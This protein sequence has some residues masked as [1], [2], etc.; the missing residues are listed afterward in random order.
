MTQAHI[1]SR[2]P[3]AQVGPTLFAG[4]PHGRLD[5]VLKAV[6]TAN[7]SCVVL[8]GDIEPEHPLEDEMCSLDASGVAWYF[9][10]GNH[11][12]DSDEFARHVWNPRTETHDVHSRV[13]ELP[14]GLKLAG[15]AGVW[16]ASVWHPGPSSMRR[17]QPAWRSRDAHARATPRQDRWDGVL[18]PRKHLSSIYPDEFDQL[19]AS[20]AD[21]LVSHEAP[22]YHPRGF[23]LL[24][25]LARSLRVRWSVHGHHHDDLNSSAVWAAQGFES[26]GVGLRGVSAL[27]SDGRW[28]T[29]IAGTYQSEGAPRLQRSSVR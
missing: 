27:H 5:Q 18:P 10:G 7:A 14:N 23:D 17:G 20:R 16:R 29:V 13:V 11:D 6:S 19:A 1:A 21:I 8:L 26:H 22:G 24:D 3:L 15:L 28:E 9:I 2:P 25:E 12:A 4:D